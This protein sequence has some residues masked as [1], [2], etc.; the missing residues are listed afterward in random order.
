MNLLIN[1]FKK[2]TIKFKLFNKEIIKLN[3]KLQLLEN[4]NMG[5]VLF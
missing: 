3:L 2:L 5:K 1:V 4:V